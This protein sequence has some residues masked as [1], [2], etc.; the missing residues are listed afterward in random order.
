[1]LVDGVLLVHVDFEEL[2][3]SIASEILVSARLVSIPCYM[4][5]VSIP[6]VTPHL[7]IKLLKVG[8]DQV[9]FTDLGKGGGLVVD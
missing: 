9:V 8:L 1:M 4:L 3:V 7:R 6:P 2:V 5:L